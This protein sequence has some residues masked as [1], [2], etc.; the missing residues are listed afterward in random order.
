MP[1]RTKTPAKDCRRDIGGGRRGTAPLPAPETPPLSAPVS[2]PPAALQAPEPRRHR[3][4]R[5][6]DAEVRQ[7][8]D[9]YVAAEKDGPNMDD[10]WAHVRARLP[11]AGRDRVPEI[12]RES[13]RPRHQ[14]QKAS[15]EALKSVVSMLQ[16]M[17]QPTDRN[18]SET[19]EIQGFR[20]QPTAT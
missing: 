9:E 10:A 11:N 4:R 16:F 2:D 5:G 19:A 8:I 12:Y 18:R 3:L 14:G 20:Y 7:S 15:S 6:T 1:R 17:L 13:D